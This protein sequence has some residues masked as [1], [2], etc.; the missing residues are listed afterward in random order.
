[1]SAADQANLNWGKYQFNN[2]SAADQAANKLA[3]AQLEEEKKQ[4]KTEQ[5][6]REYQY[7][8]MS[9]AEKAQF[10]EDKKQFGTEMAWRREELRLTGEMTLAQTQAEAGGVG[11]DWQSFLPE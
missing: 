11:G 10:E 2:L 9:A 5:A 7:K 4:F 8:N 1:M 3:Y 6:W